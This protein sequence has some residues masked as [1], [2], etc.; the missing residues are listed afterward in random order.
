VRGLFSYNY[1]FNIIFNYL[2]RVF[3]FLRTISHEFMEIDGDLEWWVWLKSWVL[4]NMQPLVL[5]L[6]YAYASLLV[7]ATL[8][9]GFF[10]HENDLRLVRRWRKPYLAFWTALQF[11]GVFGW[12]FFEGF[13]FLNEFKIPFI[14]ILNLII[15]L[16]IVEIL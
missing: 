9:H 7:L 4:L 5:Q 8:L 15:F 14:W 3:H 2:K 16:K 10:F 11:N 6:R 1:I 12:K 13:D